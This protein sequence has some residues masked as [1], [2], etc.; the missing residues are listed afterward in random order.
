MFLN[1]ILYLEDPS[2]GDEDKSDPL[3]ELESVGDDEAGGIEWPDEQ[4]QIYF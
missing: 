4:Q 1:V 2:G 3:E